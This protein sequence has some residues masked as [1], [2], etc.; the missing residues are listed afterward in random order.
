MRLA[1]CRTMAGLAAGAAIVVAVTVAMDAAGAAPA[2][3]KGAST[4]Q[5]ELTA[6]TSMKWTK[7]VKVVVSG[8]AW[9]FKSNGIPASTLTASHYAVP[10]NPLQVSAN[11]AMIISTSSVLQDQ[12]YVFQIPL[13]PRYS[14]TTT[15]NLGAIGVMLDGAVLYNP[16][17]A[18]D[19]TVATAHNFKAT[20]HGITA[21]FIDDC[22]GHPGPG[23]QYHYHGMP[24]CLVAL[25]TT[26][27]AKQVRPVTSF[28]SKTTPAVS[29]TNAA[30]RRPVL[31]GFAFDGYGI[32]DNI[33]MNGTTIPV[34]ALDACNGI[35]SAV[36]GYPQGLYHYVLENVKTKRS[37]IGCYHGVVSSAYTRAL[38]D[39]I[40]ALRPGVVLQAA[41]ARP[42]TQANA[43]AATL[44]ADPRAV[45][46]LTALFEVL[47]RA[48][49][50]G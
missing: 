15:T 44:A 19:S 6:L 33:A 24:A 38:E 28:S 27:K 7:N 25:A 47:S 46:T 4:P 32:Y 41:W 17:E 37:S 30:A 26:G 22:D 42:R 50:C 9:T 34:K 14:A 12:H 23:G 21:S 11:G 16:Y 39:S 3:P 10:A 49:G 1:R 20:R 8:D 40:R 29:E 13:T 43:T 45:V 2:P 31:V 48:T 5:S 35:F 18:N 36:P